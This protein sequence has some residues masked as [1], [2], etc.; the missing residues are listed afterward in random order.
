MGG[1]LMIDV[2]EQPHILL[3]GSTFSGKTVGLKALISSITY[4]KSPNQVNL[5]LIDLG[6]NDLMMFNSLPHL[7]CPIVNERRQAYRV[8]HSL[9]KELERKKELVIHK[10]NK[11][12]IFI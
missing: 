6:A 12:H 8:L 11:Y 9:N 10:L 4:W 2:A 3:G 5:V 1:I 7:S